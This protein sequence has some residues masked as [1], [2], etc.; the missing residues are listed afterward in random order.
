[1]IE[2]VS[3]W[4]VVEIEAEGS[5]S[6]EWLADPDGDRWLCKPAVTP[7]TACSR[8]RLVRVA[9]RGGCVEPSIAARD[10][11]TGDA[12]GQPCSASRSLRGSGE[13]LQAGAVLL[14]GIP[15]FVPRSKM[16]TGHTL[17]QHPGGA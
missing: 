17:S 6:K 14:Q 2:D 10:Y 16:R 13:E 5:D 15:G 11:P 3:S 1:M 7:E 12:K 4:S 8:R 9:R